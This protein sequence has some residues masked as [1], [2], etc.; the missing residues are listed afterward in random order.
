M[1]S[2]I[3]DL[4]NKLKK[5]LKKKVNQYYIHIKNKVFC[6]DKLNRV[7]ILNHLIFNRAQIFNIVLTKKRN[8]TEIWD[9]IFIICQIMN[10]RIET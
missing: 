3:L 4:L 9:L 2:I 8:L 6:K 7:E 5:M 10:K 1:N